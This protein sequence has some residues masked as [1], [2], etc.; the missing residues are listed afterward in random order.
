MY[1]YWVCFRRTMYNTH[2]CILNKTIAHC[3]SWVYYSR[4]DNHTHPATICTLKEISSICGHANHAIC[5]QT[6]SRRSLVGGDHTV[7]L[8]FFV[9]LS[10]LSPWHLAYIIHV[11]CDSPRQICSVGSPQYSESVSAWNGSDW[12]YVK[13][14]ATARRGFRSLSL[15]HE[16]FMVWIKH[17]FI[18]V[19]CSAT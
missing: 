15:L 12:G 6:N 17:P 5:G 3:Y 14:S 13:N 16:S 4:I 1:N 8:S 2:A 10:S 7:F 9:S 19:L 11:R 18:S